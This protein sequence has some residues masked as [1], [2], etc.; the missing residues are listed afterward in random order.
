MIQQSRVCWIAMWFSLESIPHCGVSISFSLYLGRQSHKPDPTNLGTDCVQCQT[1][2]RVTWLFRGLCV[3]GLHWGK[4]I[5]DLVNPHSPFHQKYLLTQVW[6]LGPTSD[7]SVLFVGII[8]KWD[9]VLGA[10]N[11]RFFNTKHFLIL[12]LQLQ[13]FGI[14]KIFAFNSFSGFGLGTRLVNNKIK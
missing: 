7:F 3:C 6:Y 14:L 12:Y 2:G 10:L 5:A 11:L 9:K 8:Q 13:S 1:R 4:L